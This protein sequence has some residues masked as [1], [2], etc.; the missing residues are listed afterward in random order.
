MTLNVDAQLD[1]GDFHLAARFVAGD[2]VTALFGPSGGGKSTLLAVIAGLKR[3][4][5]H[6]Y[7]GSRTLAHCGTRKH[8]PPHQRNI[9]LVFQDT[10]LFPHLTVRQNIAFA[11]KR[12]A[13]AARPEIG[14]VARFFDITAQ[15]DRPVANLSGGEKSRVALARAV[16]A[17]PDFLLLDEPFAALDGSRRR[18]FIQVLLAMHRNYRL[19]MMVVTHDIEDAAALAS[20][21]VALK[22][23]HVVAAGAFAEASAQ[24]AFQALLDAHDTGA[25]VPAHL[26]RSQHGGQLLW[27]RADQVLLATEAPRSISA[28]NVLPGAVRT[29]TV[30]A[31]GSRLIELATDVGA[32]LS[33]VTPEAADELALRPGKVAWALVKAHAL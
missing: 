26:L 2:G 11:W 12:A 6:V 25:A 17:A 5:G 1:L 3:C 4:R 10:R 23:G 13:H 31:D 20:N 19:P 30:E 8:L 22:D 15:L 9:G 32:I 14:D 27:L 29:V 21:L 24:P 16:A 33:R 28:R 18:A 7:L